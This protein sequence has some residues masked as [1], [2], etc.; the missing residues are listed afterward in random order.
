MFIPGNSGFGG[1]GGQEWGKKKQ[2]HLNQHLMGRGRE[3]ERREAAEKTERVDRPV[4]YA[5]WG[6]S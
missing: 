4:R 1:V 5:N 6:I 2:A 3:K